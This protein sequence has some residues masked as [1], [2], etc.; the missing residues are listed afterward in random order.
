MTVSAAPDSGFQD[1]PVYYNGS[2]AFSYRMLTDGHG[3]HHVENLNEGYLGWLGGGEFTA[4]SG[5]TL[6]VDLEQRHPVTR[7]VARGYVNTGSGVYTPEDFMVEWSN[8][9]STFTTFGSTFGGSTSSG[10]R[11]WAYETSD[12]VTARYWRFYFDHQTTNRW[13]FLS[14]LEVWGKEV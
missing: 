14:D 11:F 10:V 12:N 1:F 7:A 8:D 4:G 13:V 2:T 9:N 6:T 5:F 3:Q